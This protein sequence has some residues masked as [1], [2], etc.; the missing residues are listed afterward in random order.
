MTVAG[1]LTVDDVGSLTWR[2][3]REVLRDAKAKIKQAG[4]ALDHSLRKPLPR[5]TPRDLE[6]ELSGDGDRRRSR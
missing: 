2:E 1:S 5:V 4:R 3:K 6:E